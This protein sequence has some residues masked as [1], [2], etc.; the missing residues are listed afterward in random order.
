MGFP[1]WQDTEKLGLQYFVCLTTLAP[2]CRVWKGQIWLSWVQERDA[3][4]LD[5]AE[6]HWASKADTDSHEDWYPSRNFVIMCLKSPCT[7][8]HILPTWSSPFQPHLCVNPFVHQ[9][10]HVLEGDCPSV[11]C[12][13]HLIIQGWE[14]SAGWVS[15]SCQTWQQKGI[16]VNNSEKGSRDNL[17]KSHCYAHMK[18]NRK[19]CLL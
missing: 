13:S 4:Q 6:P 17:E 3:D 2:L 14:M 12:P 1:S 10:H 16:Y 18:W 11:S 8:T 9:H 19:P 5:R 7:S 15:S